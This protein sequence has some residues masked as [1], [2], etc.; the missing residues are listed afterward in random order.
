[1]ISLM[2]DMFDD[3][4]ADKIITFLEYPTARMLKDHLEYKDVLKFG[5]G[6]KW[7]EWQTLYGLAHIGNHY[8]HYLTYGGGPEGIMKNYGD[9]W[10]CWHRNWGIR[11][12]YTRIPDALEIINKNDDGCEAIKMVMRSDNYEIHDDEY[13]LDDLEDDMDWRHR[14]NDSGS[15]ADESEEDEA[16]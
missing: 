1:M 7:S 11:A 10:Y 8:R 12:T 4:I 13:Y 16:S 5:P 6:T 15:E 14:I 3:I 9:G 2:C